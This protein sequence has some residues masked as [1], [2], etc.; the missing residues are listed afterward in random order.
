[1]MFAECVTENTIIVKKHNILIRILR[2]T[3]VSYC[4]HLVTHLTNLL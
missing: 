4:L 2:S 3:V 1:M